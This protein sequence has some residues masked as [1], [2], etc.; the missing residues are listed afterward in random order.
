MRALNLFFHVILIWK[1]TSALGLASWG[2]RSAMS[3]GYCICS[4]PLRNG[5]CVYE[6][7]K[8]IFSRNQMGKVQKAVCTVLEEIQFLEISCLS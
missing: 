8:P 1:I 6:N 5:T 7:Y 2:V 4:G 3:K